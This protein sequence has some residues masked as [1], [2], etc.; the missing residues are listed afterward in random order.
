MEKSNSTSLLNRPSL[1]QAS[2]RAESTE[3]QASGLLKGLTVSSAL[4]TQRQSD[5][6]SNTVE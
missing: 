5:F 6:S 1:N 2:E 4:K 3:S